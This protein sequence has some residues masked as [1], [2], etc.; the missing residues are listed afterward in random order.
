MCLPLAVA[1]GIVSAAGSLTSGIQGM[2]QANY[3]ARVNK[4]NARLSEEQARDSIDR[5]RDEARSF[6][7][8][9]GQVKGQEVASMAANGI[10]T[11]FGTALTVQQDTAAGA[12]EDASNLYH[13]INERTRG[14]DI[15]ARNYRE[16]A[17]AAKARGRTAMVNSVFQAGSSLMGGFSQNSALRARMGITGGGATGRWG[18]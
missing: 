10:D 15:N 13:N 17:A 6:Y 3:E 9:V 1:A 12:D 8:Q 11:G 18:G 14:F 4:E 5:G 16:E 7:R 2:V